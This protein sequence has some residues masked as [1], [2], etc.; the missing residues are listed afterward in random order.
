MQRLR[1][2][3]THA[4]NRANQVGTRTQ[5]R[6]FTQILDAVAFSRHR[7]GIRIFNPAGDF[8]GRSLNF[9]T[10]TLARDATT[11]PVTITEQPVVRCRTSSL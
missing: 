10:L 11:L 5:V 2:R 8:N 9:E 7:I 1:Q 3:M 4:S 6:H